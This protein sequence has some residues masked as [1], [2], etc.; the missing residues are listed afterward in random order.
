MLSTNFFVFSAI[1]V[2][3]FTALICSGNCIPILKVSEYDSKFS[4]PRPNF[5]TVWL[6]KQFGTLCQAHGWDEHC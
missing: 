5:H 1:V 3:F 4:S 6:F 2:F